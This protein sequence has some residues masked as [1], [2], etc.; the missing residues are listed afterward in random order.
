VEGC[1]CHACRH[2]T[3]A[4]IHHLHICKEILA[5]VLVYHHNAHQLLQLFAAARHHIRNNSFDAWLQKV[6]AEM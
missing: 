5:E 6:R 3:R 4:Y 2:H 1:K